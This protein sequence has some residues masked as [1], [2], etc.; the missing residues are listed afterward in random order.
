VLGEWFFYK[1]FTPPG[2]WR[3]FVGRIVLATSISPRWGLGKGVLGEWFF[4]QAF[5]PAGVLDRVYWSFSTLHQIAH[6]KKQM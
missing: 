4:L 2:F 5:H 3:R 6:C 1:H